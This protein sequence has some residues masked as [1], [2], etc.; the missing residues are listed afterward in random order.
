M[1]ES[2][3]YVDKGSSISILSTFKYDKKYT[4]E[5][6]IYSNNSLD[7]D[8]GDNCKIET[9]NNNKYYFVSSDNNYQATTMINDYVYVFECSNEKI[10][11]EIIKKTK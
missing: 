6:L 10:L 9:I 11:K 5:L 3:I 8:I 4:I 1:V 7:I 2:L